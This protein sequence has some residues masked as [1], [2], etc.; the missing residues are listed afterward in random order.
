MARLLLNAK[1]IQELQPDKRKRLE[2]FDTK[3]PG[4]SIQITPNGTKSF[5]VYYRFGGTLRCY[6]LGRVDQITLQD[7]RAAARDA[8]Q[9][10]YKGKDDPAVVDPAVKRK[11]E[12]NAE[13]FPEVAAAYIKRYA[14]EEKKSWRDDARI[15]KNVL[16][17]KFKNK[18]ARELTRADVR[19]LLEHIANDEGHP[20]MANRVR[21]CLSKIYEWAIEADLLLPGSNPC[22]GIAREEESSRERVLTNDEVKSLWHVFSEDDSCAGDVLKLRLI[23]GQRGGELRGMRWDEIDE[24]WW[25]SI[26]AERSKNKKAHRVWLS[27]PAQ[28]IIEARLVKNNA[29]SEED[30]SVF[31]F[32]GK[33]K[34]VSIG[35]TGCRKESLRVQPDPKLVQEWEPRDLRRTMATGMAEQLHIPESTI[36]KVLNHS[37]PYRVKVTGVYNR[38]QYDPEK[39]TA[40]EAW[41]KHLV[42]IVSGLTVVASKAQ[43]SS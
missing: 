23:T 15:I 33:T 10:A 37:D 38:Y 21:A 30:R 12:R 35:E 20:V 14:Q 24:T 9:I 36:S 16:N 4:F 26:P 13:M 22:I 2:F 31:V 7:A 42:V 19:S 43:K 18:R 29:L 39:K 27:E 8:K 34:A 41:G 40:L 6:S 25:W 32:R 11:E 17:P 5:R 1:V 3:E 28:K